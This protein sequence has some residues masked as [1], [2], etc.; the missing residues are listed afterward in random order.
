MKRQKLLKTIKE[1]GATMIR[2]AALMKYG[3]AKTDT[4]SQSPGMPK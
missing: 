4:G 2:Q 3:K 1:K